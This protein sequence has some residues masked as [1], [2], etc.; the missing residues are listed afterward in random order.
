MI[1]PLDVDFSYDACPSGEPYDWTNA[2]RGDSP[3]DNLDFHLDLGCGKVKKGRIGVDRYPAAGVDIVMDLEHM[4]RPFPAADVDALEL[5]WVEFSA[6]PFGESSIRSIISHHFLEHIGP[7]FMRLMNECYRVLEPGGVF[8][9]IVPL[10]PSTAA[11]QD[12]DHKRYFMLDTFDSFCGTPGETPQNC[13][14]ASF[15]VPYT[16]ARFEMVHKDW[17]ALVGDP[18]AH[19]CARELRVAMR[20]QK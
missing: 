14:L 1:D 6:L 9:A 7:G 16:T 8:R 20:A 17:T 18:W 3:W 2:A 5:P 4:T 10:F 19:A 12:P 13:W 15:S 11:V